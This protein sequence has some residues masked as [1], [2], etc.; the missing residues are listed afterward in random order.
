MTDQDKLEIR[1]ISAPW[2]RGVSLLIRQGSLYGKHVVMETHD[3]YMVT[4]PTCQISIDS[5]Q[6]LMDDLWNAGIR[7]TEGTGSAGSLKATENHLGD[8]RR[9]V[10][11][12]M[13]MDV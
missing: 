2:H 3:E 10:F 4:D 8:M 13:G 7:P 1:A 5:A 6:T 12:Q 11:K 9:I